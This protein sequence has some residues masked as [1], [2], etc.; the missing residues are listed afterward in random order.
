MNSFSSAAYV[1]TVFHKR[2]APVSHGFGYKVFSLAL[3]VDEIDD[4]HRALRLFSRN[5]W[6]LVSFHDRD[7]GARDGVAVAT[8]IRAV[9]AGAG[10]AHAGVRITLLCYPRLFGFVFNPLSVYFCHGADGGLGAIVYEVSNTFGERTSYVIPVVS[11]VTPTDGEMVRQGCDKL[12]YVSPYTSRQ[13]RY[14]FHVRAPGDNIFVGVDFW[15]AERPVLKTYFSGARVALTT[16]SLAR[17][18]ARHPLMTFKVVAGIH[19]EAARL[20]LKGV[21]LVERHGSPRYSIAIV[22]THQR[23]I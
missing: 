2:L 16:A 20:W 23:E 4:L 21:P 9:L 19:W 17:L 11:P 12:M 15:E 22:P 1:G 18:V 3:D 13:G 8:Q 7:H 14:Q 6:N 5:H 10:L